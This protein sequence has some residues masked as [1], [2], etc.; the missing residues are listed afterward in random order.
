M[1]IIFLLIIVS[2]FGYCELSFYEYSHAHL[3]IYTYSF[4]L[5][6][7]RGVDFGA[8]G[9]RLILLETTEQFPK[10]VVL[11]NTRLWF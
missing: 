5:T 3:S 9:R 10:V 11:F 1:I 2:K 7:Y 4:L 8:S 6:I